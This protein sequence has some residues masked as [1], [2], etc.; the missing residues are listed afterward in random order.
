MLEATVTGK[1]S[2]FDM[3]LLSGAG[4]FSSLLLLFD[5]SG[6]FTTTKQEKNLVHL[7]EK[8]LI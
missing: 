3:W 4:E 5:L 8:I 1:L 7:A 6:A 2:G